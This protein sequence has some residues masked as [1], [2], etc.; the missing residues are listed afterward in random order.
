MCTTIRPKVTT[1]WATLAQSSQRQGFESCHWQ[2]SVFLFC[3]C[4]VVPRPK[5][6][7]LAH[8]IIEQQKKK[9]CYIK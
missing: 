8:N 6:P 9:N 1:Q 2:K 7:I 3:H 5:P 4:W